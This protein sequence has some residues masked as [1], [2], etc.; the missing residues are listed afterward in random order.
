[1]GCVSEL[2]LVCS[3][4][5]NPRC[6]YPRCLPSLSVLAVCPRAHEVRDADDATSYALKCGFIAGA[7]GADRMGAIDSRITN[8]NCVLMRGWKGER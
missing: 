8:R 2:C 7:Y 1:M 5:L 4:C 6:L 3:R